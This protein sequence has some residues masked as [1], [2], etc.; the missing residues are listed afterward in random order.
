MKRKQYPY[1]RLLPE[2]SLLAP[3]WTSPQHDESAIDAAE[4][5]LQMDNLRGLSGAVF[6]LTVLL[7]VCILGFYGILYEAMGVYGTI[8][9]VAM[10]LAVG[11]FGAILFYLMTAVENKVRQTLNR[12]EWKEKSN[13]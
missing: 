4:I 1:L 2:Q 12:D 9:F 3:S 11:L 7:E 6:L 8:V 5:C 10:V 13:V